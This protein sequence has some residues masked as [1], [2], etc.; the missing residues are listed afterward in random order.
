MVLSMHKRSFFLF[1]VFTLFFSCENDEELLKDITFVDCNAC[2]PD[3]PFTADIR[4]KLSD[5]YKL[6]SANEIVFLDIY[7][8]NLEDEVLFTSYQTTSTE[9]TINLPINKKYC[10]MA[11]YYIDNKTYIAV[12]SVTPRVKYNESSCDEPCYYTAPRSLNLRLKHTK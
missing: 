10:I 11:T 9:T 1:L 5:T 3:E 6:G 2:T 8:G 7:E 12:N 4:M